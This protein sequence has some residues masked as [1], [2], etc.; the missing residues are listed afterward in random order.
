MLC[1]TRDQAGQCSCGCDSGA[2]NK[3][4]CCFCHKGCTGKNLSTLCSKACTPGCSC[5]SKPGT[6][7]RHTFCKTLNDIKIP[8]GCGC[9]EICKTGKCPCHLGS[10]SCPSNCCQ[11]GQKSLKCVI[12][13]LLKFFQQVSS[14][15]SKCFRLCCEFECL[16]KHCEAVKKLFDGAKRKACGTCEKANKG[17]GKNVCGCSK[18]S[19]GKT[20]PDCCDQAPNGCQNC[21]ECQEILHGRKLSGALET[22]RYS[23]PCGQDLSRVL[24]DFLDYCTG[25][26]R[27][28]FK[29]IEDAV[30]PLKSKHSPCCSTGQPCSPSCSA[31]QALRG[32][33][34]IM[35]ILA[36]G[37][38]S[39]YD[40]SSANW[41]SLC[42][43]GSKCCGSSS[44]SCSHSGSCPDKGCCEKCPKRLCA[45]IFL[46]FIPA[47]YF[48]LKIVFERCD[49]K[50]SSQWPR[51]QTKITQGSI[52]DFLYAWGVHSYLNP[53]TH[54]VVL[55]VLLGNLFTSDSKGSL[56]KIYD[57]VSLNYFSHS[58]SP[59]S[60]PKDPLT[61]RQMLLWLYGL[62]FQKSFPSLVSLCRTL[63]LPLDNAF[64]P[65][66]VCYYLHLSCFLLPVSFIST[67]QHSQSHVGDFFSDAHSE[68]LKFFYPSDPS[69]LLD[70]L[71]EYLRKVFPALKF[72]SIQCANDSARAGWRDCAFG[73]SCAQA[74]EDSF[75]SAVSTSTSCCQ[76]SAPK[77]YLC[78]KTYE[79]N[80]H[81][82]CTKQ[83]NKCIGPTGKCS[84]ASATNKNP[85]TDAHT[86]DKCKN[87]CPHP[88]MAFLCDCDSTVFKSLFKLPEDSSV[89]PMGFKTY[90]LPSPARWGYSLSPVLEAFCR[91]GF[92]PLTRLLKFLTRVSRHPPENL[93][94][95]FAFFMK[96]AEALNSKSNPLKDAFP[97]YVDGEPGFYPATML[98][99]AL[100]QLLGSK[101]SHSSSSHTP[102][103]LYSLSYCEGPKGSSNPTC[104]KYLYPLIQDASD[105]FGDDFIQTYLS[106]ICYRAE[107][108]KTLLEEFR[109]KFSD[110]CSSGK[111]QKIV[112]CPCALPFI[113]SLGFTFV[114]PGGLNC[115]NAQG[116]E[117]EKHGGKADSKPEQCTR[118]TCSQFL[119][120]LGLVANGDLFTNLLEEIDNFLWSIR[121]PFFFG[122]LY[123]WFFV[124]SYFFYV[125]LI[126]LDTFHTGSHLHL[127]RSF[128]ILPSTL[129]S[130]AS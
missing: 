93:G 98:K 12:M 74:L 13:R 8:V 94:E 2:S 40:S 43:S 47:L 59:K 106:W 70:M 27:P 71:F 73:Q 77:G 22:L 25:V 75:S 116:T 92:Y 11:S 39:S 117:H 130:D 29:V 67:V 79:S 100:E 28:K 52:V 60:P 15:T 76:S 45:K 110:C 91:N 30:K 20:C 107:K 35:A 58:P 105:I 87:P 62:R 108:F 6:C 64:H 84:D 66:A 14:D 122:F 68:I 41:D 89:P 80:V 5:A 32:H 127:P 18:K 114:S 104:G 33:D 42:P 53:S 10:G 19:A 81:E 9:L 17:G 115:V 44:C 51:W 72:L 3:S 54:A 109:Q 102:A 82:H 95:L 55:P 128:K 49:S 90:R 129:F 123:V 37:Y 118:K 34:D 99:T 112:E 85:D 69:D 31:C 119:K 56:D 125:I 111:C 96:F 97:K 26:F 48:G 78:T 50:N 4:C 38:F 23:T 21:S 24:D 61:V 121:F 16:K 113:Y 120:Q 103:S 63:S 65:D 46:G 7:P 57:L 88:L 124:L 86:S 83:G 1:G 126:K 36:G 101:T